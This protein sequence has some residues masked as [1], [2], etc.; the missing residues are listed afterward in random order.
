MYLSGNVGSSVPSASR[1][2]WRL[3]SM[4]VEVQENTHIQWLKRSHG[5]D[6]CFWNTMQ[7][8]LTERL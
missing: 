5:K 2:L 6:W 8:I 3:I 7:A 4:N 1:C